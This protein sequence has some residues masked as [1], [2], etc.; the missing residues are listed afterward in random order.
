MS[1]VRGFAP[2]NPRG[3]SLALIESVQAILN[4]YREQLPLTL[5]QIYYRAVTKKLLDKT[6][7][8]YSRLCEV[9]GRARRGKLIPMSAIRD[10]GFRKVEP[11]GWN[12]EQ[13]LIDAIFQ[14]I[15]GFRL[16]RQSNQ[17]ERLI[18]WCEAGGMV[19]QLATVAEDY[20]VPVCS[21]GGFDSLT[22]KHDAA[23]WISDMER[24][25]VLHL[26]DHDPSGVHMFSALN[27][28]VNQFIE[29]FGGDVTF[30]RLAVT[31]E[32]IEQHK[33]P[34]APPKPTDK[35]SFTG[36]TTQCEALDPKALAEIVRGA[37][38]S[39]QDPLTRQ[40]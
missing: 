40:Y 23:Q 26:G 22:A 9:I 16:D 6:E 20:G 18:L 15:N 5:R 30:T 17:K 19:P 37:I 12:N 4:E 11:D 21:S 14:T 32:Q 8:D 2:Y 27:E 34:T 38:E 33:L 13:H 10:D 29:H 35:R 36:L 7:R 1:R 31:P 25:T 28:D 39:R 3:K 24:V